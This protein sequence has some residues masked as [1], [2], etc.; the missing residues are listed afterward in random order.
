MKYGYQF[1]I[2]AIP[3]DENYETFLKLAKMMLVKVKEEQGHADAKIKYQTQQ[4][5]IWV[6]TKRFKYLPMWG[7]FLTLEVQEPVTNVSAQWEVAG[8]KRLNAAS[9]VIPLP[10]LDWKQ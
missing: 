10:H 5:Y 4:S 2:H 9:E 7:R 1:Q 3:G 8:S 6:Q